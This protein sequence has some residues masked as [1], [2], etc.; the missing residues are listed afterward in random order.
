MPKKTELRAAPKLFYVVVLL[1]KQ[2]AGINTY[3]NNFWLY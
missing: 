3:V 2:E 1:E